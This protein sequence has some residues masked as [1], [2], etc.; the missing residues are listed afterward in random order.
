MGLGWPGSSGTEGGWVG[1]D[2]VRMIGVRLSIEFYI[3]LKHWNFLLIMLCYMK[4]V[5][6]INLFLMFSG[7]MVVQ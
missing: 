2:L 7:C 4:A 3:Y 6:F 1:L 5:C